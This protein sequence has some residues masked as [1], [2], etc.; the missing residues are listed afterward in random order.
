MK[1]SQCLN[2]SVLVNLHQDF[3]MVKQVLIEQQW[4]LLI[5]YNN[6]GKE[7]DKEKSCNHSI[8]KL[9]FFFWKNYH[10][11]GTSNDV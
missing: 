1:K 5:K 4:M 8:N 10:V 11:I 3:K 9:V 7:K 2:V 6:R